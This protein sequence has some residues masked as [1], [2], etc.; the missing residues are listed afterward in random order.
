MS[1]FR[2]LAMF[3]FCFSISAQSA[4]LKGSSLVFDGIT[5]GALTKVVLG[6]LAGVSYVIDPEVMADMS[7]F[8]IR[9][10]SLTKAGAVE[11]LAGVLSSR[12]FDVRSTKGG[13]VRVS[14]SKQAQGVVYE[15]GEEQVIYRPRFRSM[16][17]IVDLAKGFFPVGKWS[18]ERS[19]TPQSTAGPATAPGA[20]ERP[21]V[22]GGAVGNAFS[23]T[24]L[25][26]FIYEG[27]KADC[28]RLRAFLAE[29]DTK[30]EQ[31]LVQAALYEVSKISKESSAVSV[32]ADILSGKFGI[33]LGGGAVTGGPWSVSADI[34]GVRAV[35]SALSSDTR[36]KSLARP[37]I[38]LASG[39]MGR[40]SVGDET[41]V[42]GA[43]TTQAGG[44]ATQSIEY[45]PSGHI[46]TVTP[47]ILADGVELI[48]TQQSSSF[49]QTTTG[50]NVSPTLLKREV[51]SRL[52]VEPGA[53]V[54]LGGM[55]ESRTGADA[56]GPRWFPEWAKKKSDDSSETELLLVLHVQKV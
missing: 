3:F 8:T 7:G 31:V 4:D 9:A 55:Q 32:A 18:F 24:D 49:V 5:P 6:D 15:P 44:V 35:F 56:A 20:S 45:R 23:R 10:D 13:S 52:M 2:W 25:D 51:S 30:P 17:Y 1:V 46:L 50:V 26:V 12:G 21:P 53:F 28:R 40:V 11:W 39:A 27:T 48:I 43:V 47:T 34:G 22:G 41:P 33:T 36:F 37:E 38:R 29:I 14:K 54:V 42:L 16:A 19:V